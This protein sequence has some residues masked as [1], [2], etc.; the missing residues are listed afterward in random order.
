M[1]TPGEKSYEDLKNNES[2]QSDTNL[3]NLIKQ[4][5]EI[6]DTNKNNDKIE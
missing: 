1:A 6:K 2:V 3:Q 5:D 4:I